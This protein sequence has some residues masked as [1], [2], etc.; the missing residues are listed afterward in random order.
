LSRI[1]GGRTKVTVKRKMLGLVAR[2]WQGGEVRGQ[3]AEDSNSGV[4]EK[5]DKVRGSVSVS[6]I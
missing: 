2:M 3:V 1:L 5:S 6:E 4:T